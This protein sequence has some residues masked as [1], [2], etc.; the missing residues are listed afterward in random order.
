L[1]GGPNCGKI[2]S[3]I[4]L[5]KQKFRYVELV[6]ELSLTDFKLKYQGSF[7]GYLWSLAKPLM[8]FAILYIVF[9]KFL[10]IG[11][12]IPHY[13]LYLLTGVV[14]WMF[15]AETTATSVTSIVAKGDL[16]RK[17]Y[18]PRIV[19][20]VSGAATS[21]LTFLLNFLAVM[22]FVLVNG[23]PV[24]FRALLLPIILIEFLILVVGVGF[25][26][27]SLFVKY[28]D[29]THIWEIVLQG[30][31]YGTPILYPL[32]MVPA[33]YN[34]LLLL[35]PVAQ[36]I[37]DARYLLISTDSATAFKLLPLKF[38]WI[39]YTLPIIIFLLGYQ[40]FNRSAAKFAE[41]V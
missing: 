35:S 20:V 26:L 11:G 21:M 22:F 29:I 4:K 12:N 37:Q 28:R 2:F 5:N 40:I 6:K 38:V 24:G 34:K 32:T 30:A 39:P 3:V 36:I 14:F 8:L 19:L 23:V 31:F 33:P 27:S 7:L 25:F 10:R 9:T 13:A 1:N 41:E 16:I 18:F 15:F 17:I